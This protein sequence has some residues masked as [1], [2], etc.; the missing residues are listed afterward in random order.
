MRIGEGGEDAAAAEVDSLRCRQ[1]ALVGADA[2]DD[3]IPRDREG[4][5]GRQRRVHRPDDAVRDDHARSLDAARSRP[6]AAS[7]ACLAKG[8]RGTIELP[9]GGSTWDSRVRLR[10]SRSWCS[11]SPWAPISSCGAVGPGTPSATRTSTCS[12][13]GAPDRA[14]PRAGRRRARPRRARPPL[15]RRRATADDAVAADRERDGRPRARHVPLDA[16]P[17]RRSHAARGGEAGGAGVPRPRPRAAARR[18]R[19][20]RRR[21]ERR[22]LP[23]P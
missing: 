12:G 8:T 13:C 17:G 22:R 14:A 4:R 20:V 15:P 10:S 6:P 16:L 2:A 9:I 7:S 21:R 1:S 3:P 19:D 11:H 5:R 23:D 18:A